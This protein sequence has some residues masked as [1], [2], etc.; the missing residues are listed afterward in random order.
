MYIDNKQISSLNNNNYN[1]ISN[2]S[3]SIFYN[4]TTSNDLNSQRQLC[5]NTSNLPHCCDYFHTSD[6]TRNNNET[7]PNSNVSFYDNNSNYKNHNYPYVYQ[8]GCPTNYYYDKT[9][10]FLTN[11]TTNYLYSNKNET[12]NTSIAQSQCYNLRN[13]TNQSL[14]QYNTSYNNCQNLP[15]YKDLKISNKNNIKTQIPVTAVTSNICDD[16]F[17]NN[18]NNDKRIA[19]Q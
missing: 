12:Q 13:F 7:R 5:S 1:Q 15:L 17:N 8:Y 6:L 2:N 10:P 4:Q 14:S 11:N 16:K 19:D 3:S 9:Q 18:N